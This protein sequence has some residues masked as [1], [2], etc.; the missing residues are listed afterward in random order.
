MDPEYC[1]QRAEECVRW[2]RRTG[3][4]SERMKL[5]EMAHG[6]LAL[7]DG[8]AA[9]VPFDLNEK[10]ANLENGTGRP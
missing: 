1:R 4:N 7:V 8:D 3:E 6:W 9:L 2:A 10:A 5:L